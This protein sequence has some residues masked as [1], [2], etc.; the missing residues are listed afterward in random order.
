MVIFWKLQDIHAVNSSNRKILKLKTNFVQNIKIF[1]YQLAVLF[2]GIYFFHFIICCTLSRC[3]NWIIQVCLDLTELINEMET[4][5]FISTWF[6]KGIYVSS[7]YI[8]VVCK[9]LKHKYKC[10]LWS[11]FL[12]DW[13]TWL[14]GKYVPV[15]VDLYSTQNLKCKYIEN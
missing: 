5:P 10:N 12:D 13:I 15:H 14:Y 4:F 3:C 8:L 11:Q 7:N 6:L 1:F 9:L 2:F